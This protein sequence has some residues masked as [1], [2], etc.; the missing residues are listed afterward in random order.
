[1]FIYIPIFPSSSFFSVGAVMYVA[2]AVMHAS[3]LPSGILFMVLFSF[4][5]TARLSPSP[6][7][8]IFRFPYLFPF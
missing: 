2:P 5:L 6:L 1:M 3:Q 8:E 4:L 7:Y